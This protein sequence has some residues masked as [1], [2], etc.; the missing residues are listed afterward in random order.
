MSAQLSK[1][2]PR[3]RRGHTL[4]N[5]EPAKR[6]RQVQRGGKDSSN[7]D[8]DDEHRREKSAKA[9]LQWMQDH[10]KPQDGVAR[11]KVTDDLVREAARETS[12]VMEILTK[13][14]QQ[15][16]KGAVPFEGGPAPQ[17]VNGVNITR[18]ASLMSTA[19]RVCSDEELSA[20]STRR[21]VQE[22]FKVWRQYYVAGVAYAHK[23][24]NEG[25]CLIQGVTQRALNPKASVVYPTVSKVLSLVRNAP[26][27]AKICSEEGEQFQKIEPWV[28]RVDAPLARRGRE[29]LVASVFPKP[30]LCGVTDPCPGVVFLSGV[31]EHSDSMESFSV[32]HQEII[33]RQGFDKVRKWGFL[34]FAER[35][36][37]CYNHLGSM[38]LFPELD[39]DETWVTHG[40]DLMTYFIVPLL[41]GVG[42]KHDRQLDFERLS[43]MGYSEG[44]FGALQAATQYPDVFSLVVAASPSTGPEW[45][46]YIPVPQHQRPPPAKKRLRM[47]LVA[48]GENDRTGVDQPV[49]LQNLLRWLDQYSV[50]QYASVLTH[51]YAAIPHQMVWEWLFNRWPAFHEVF[52]RGNY[53]MKHPLF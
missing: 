16:R 28:F 46:S 36:K 41:H 15:L 44:A 18:Q 2:A 11:S 26:D 30:G 12:Q 5:Q 27:E 53:T 37:Q 21:G 25:V 39:R 40:E 29:R 17:Q 51:F 42:E 24:Y 14:R 45:W 3:T 9:F 52:W 13:E 47:V 7:I 35:D 20:W 43:I 8:V 34:R 33:F 4:T 10:E 49:N 23:H 38:L 32:N 19:D 50:S 6:W 48:L 1:S 22:L 31:G